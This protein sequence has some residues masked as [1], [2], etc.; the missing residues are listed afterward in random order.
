ME[1]DMKKLNYYQD[2][3]AS[4]IAELNNLKKIVRVDWADVIEEYPGEYL[5]ECL[6][7]IEIEDSEGYVFNMA[8]HD[9]ERSRMLYDTDCIILNILA[10]RIFTENNV[11]C[12][13]NFPLNLNYVCG[14]I[15]DARKLLRMKNR[16]ED[17]A[18]FEFEY[19]LMDI[20]NEKWVDI[21]NAVYN[22][23][24]GCGR[25]VEDWDKLIYYIQKS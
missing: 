19:C 23:S 3:L 6:S 2:Y 20:C 25:N 12:P 24:F 22:D 10:Q 14:L 13:Y 17:L 15:N 16:N 1:N 21:S 9:P 4:S 5:P 7:G 11:A 8:I 18:T